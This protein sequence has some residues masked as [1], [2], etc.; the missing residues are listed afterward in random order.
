MGMSFG[1]RAKGFLCQHPLSL[2]RSQIILKLDLAAHPDQDRIIIEN[3]LVVD[4][5]IRITK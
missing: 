1:E 4:K 3:L 2:K 5:K